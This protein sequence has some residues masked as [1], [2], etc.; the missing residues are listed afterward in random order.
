LLFLLALLGG[1]VF[2]ALLPALRGSKAPETDTPRM[3]VAKAAPSPIVAKAA[4]T[5]AHG[6][7][8]IRPQTSPA[9]RPQRSPEQAQ[10][11]TKLIEEAALHPP[12]PPAPSRA[13]PAWLRFA[14]P[15]PSFSGRALVVIVLDDL[16]LDQVRTA[17]AIRLPGPV[18]TSFMT[19]ANDLAEQTDAARR[20][21][22]ELL[23]HVPMEAIDGREDPGKQA[24]YTS[25]SRE[26]IVERL[27][28]GLDRFDGYVGINNHMGSKFTA[29][30]QVMAPVIAELRARGLLFL[31]SRTTPRS[32]GLQLAAADGV[33]HAARDVFLDNDL[34]PVAIARQLA[35]VETVARHNRSAIAI[36]HA[37]DTTL[38]A[39]HTWLP[40]LP[41]KGLVLVPLSAVV[42]YRMATERV[43]SQ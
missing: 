31:D 9:A 4:P 8:A 41:G 27:R 3:I 40:T 37:H 43:V 24:L 16:G 5:L 14:V 30:T 21:G 32:V 42:R 20:V 29:D 28:W 1:G 25:Q 36:G 35:L 39:L 12:S 33:P 15:A 7:P 17:E 18:T 22:H 23:L 11:M 19:Y 34:A 10:A 6:A 2:L 13:E 38:A 26:E